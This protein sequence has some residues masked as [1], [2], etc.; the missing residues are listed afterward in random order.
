MTLTLLIDLDDTLLGN[1]IDTFLPAYLKAL[2]KQLIDHVS[3]EKMSRNLLSATKVM[4]QNDTAALSL[5]EAFDGAFYPSIGKTKSELRSLLEQFYDH[6]FPDLQPLTSQR[7]EAIKLVE[8]AVNQGH[9]LVVATNPIFPRMAILHRLTWAG[10][11]TDQYPFKIVTSFE[12]FHYAKP[13]P[14]YYAE[15]L[16]QLGWPN[17]PAVMIGNSLED[18]LIPASKLGMPVFWINSQP[19]QLP[20]DFHPLSSIGT[21]ED[22]PA[23][24]D[25]VNNADLKQKFD[26]PQALLPVLKSTPAALQTLAGNLTERQW[27]QRPE[28]KEWSMTE[29]ICHLR[30]V[31]REV[32]IPRIEKL[33]AGDVPF[34]AGINT[35]SWIEERNYSAENGQKAL[36][37]YVEIRAQLIKLLESIP[38]NGWQQRAIHA[39]F[40]PTNL[41][42]LVSFITTHD[43]SHVQQS[44]AAV[45]VLL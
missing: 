17:Q 20:S 28:P 18:D 22:V 35:D 38:E 31:D 9:T 37:E 44:Q 41:M 43:R 24:I 2:G 12:E 34:L 11:P 7:V 39:I 45:R 4:L 33:A 36:A 10:L 32:N 3:P 26:T 5:E 14:A 23:W 40:G 29:I 27:A 42:E 1:N 25:K 21:L 19:D 13:N 30:D 8:R 6:V 16:A 15:I